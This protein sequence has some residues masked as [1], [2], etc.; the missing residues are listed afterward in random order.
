MR[1]FSSSAAV[2]VAVLVVAACAGAGPRPGEGGSA[3]VVTP[4]EQAQQ[5]LQRA[6]E[7]QARASEQSQRAAAAMAEVRQK[8]QA[9][10]AAQLEA[11]REAQKARELQLE[12][13]RVTAR[14]ADQARHSQQDATR[15]LA[16]TTQRLDRGQQLVRGVVS[17]SDGRTLVVQPQGGSPMALDIVGD[18]RVRIDGRQASASEIR[19]GESALVSYE[20]SGTQ[21]TAVSV[22]VSRGLPRSAPSPDQPPNR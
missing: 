14:A 5:A 15:A 11:E 21:P 8:Q 20:M 2:A 18:T 10:Q 17:R 4:Q 3:R 1:M 16:E 9:L 6:R 13:N 7:A 22:Q 12:A 19:Q